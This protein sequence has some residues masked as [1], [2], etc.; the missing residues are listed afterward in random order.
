MINKVTEAICIAINEEFG[1]EYRI[2][3]DEVRQDLKEP[4]FF[5]L[6][7]NTENRLFFNKRYFMRNMFCIH[8]FP[9]DEETGNAECMSAAERLFSCLE[10]INVN[11]DLTMGADMKSEFSD[12]V[13]LFFVNYDFFVYKTAERIPAM[14]DV[15]ED[16]SVKGE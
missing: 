5:V 16:I 1:D 9:K 10:W 13:L 15:K 4:C 8:Y 12:G 14:E 3:T 11:G 6:C 7:V 2:Y